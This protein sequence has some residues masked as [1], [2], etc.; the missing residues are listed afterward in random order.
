[1]DCG[2]TELPNRGGTAIKVSLGGSLQ[3]RG[4]RRATPGPHQ[5]LGLH[6]T[7][8]G[9]LGPSRPCQAQVREHQG[10]PTQAWSD[11]K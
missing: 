10:L 4:T 3:S 5:S 1:M 8:S 9:S 6:N 2:E 11:E 7:S